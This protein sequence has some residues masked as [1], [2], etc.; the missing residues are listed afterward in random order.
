MPSAGFE[1]AISAKEAAAEPRLRPGGSHWEL[2][3]VDK[4]IFVKIGQQ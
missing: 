2:F 3:Y 4:Q 1:P